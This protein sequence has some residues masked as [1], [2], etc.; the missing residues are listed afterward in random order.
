MLFQTFTGIYPRSKQ[1]IKATRDYDRKRIDKKE[2]EKAFKT[3]VKKLFFI[4]KKY[5]FNHYFDGMLYFQDIFRPFTESLRG[6]EVGALTRFFENNTFYKQPIITEKIENKKRFL[7]NYFYLDLFPKGEKL[8]VLPGP[9]TFSVLSKNK[10]YKDDKQAMFDFAKAL[11][12]EAKQLEKIGF[13][14]FIFLEP[15]LTFLASRKKIE[16]NQVIEAAKSLTIASKGIKSET[17]AHT[18]FGD[19]SLIQ[20]SISEA[21]LSGF[22]V[23][24][25]ETNENNINY[26]LFE[27]KAILL[28]IVDSRNTLI[29][30]A[31]QIIATTKKIQEKTSLKKIFLSGNTCLEHL[32][33]PFAE[34]KIKT[35][36]KAIKE[37]EEKK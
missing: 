7:H 15:S 22:G 31:K 35:I 27:D 11:N 20:N 4:Q 37:L 14:L 2:L 18:Y 17:I 29:E 8:A 19:F 26:E 25:T 9:F 5:G 34:K 6:L 1:L 16:K 10:F 33:L 3:D 13:T 32:P 24:L 36:S 21:K 12:K 23:D 28:G 30:P